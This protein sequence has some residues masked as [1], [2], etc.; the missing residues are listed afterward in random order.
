M[1]LSRLRNI[2][3]VAHIDAGKTTVTERI[4]YYTGV[5]HRMGEVHQGTTVMD[6]MEEERERG[7]TIT[8]AA[9]RCPWRDHAIQII[10]TPG[11]VDFTAEVSRSLRVLDGA[12]VVV[13]AVAGVQAQT[14]TV[15]RQA[16]ANEVPWIAF[17]NKMDRQGAD[18]QAAVESLRR[19]VEAPAV[20][21]QLPVGSGGEFE[22]VI[23]L[24]EL[25]LLCWRE[26]DKGAEV[27][28]RELTEEQ[29]VVALEARLRLC[30]AVAETS[31]DLLDAYLE[32]GDLENAALRAGL[33]RATL[34][35]RL[36]PV[37]A[38]SALRFAGIQPLLDGVL[39]WLPSPLER[40]PVRGH[41]PG[42]EDKEEIRDPDPAAPLTALVFKVAHDPHGDLCYLRVYSGILREGDQLHNARRARPER[43][44]AIYRMHADHRERLSEAG[45]GEIV[46]LPGLKHAQTGDTLFL[47]GHAIALEPIEFPD[48]VI[49]QTVEPRSLAERDKLFQALRALDREDPTLRV[50]VDEDTGQAMLAGMGE[51][52]LEVALHRLERDFR[53][54]ARAGRPVVA[55]RET[56]QSA[57]HG[58]GRAERPFADGR[59][60]AEAEVRVTP[61]PET[62]PTLRLAADLDGFAGAPRKVFESEAPL[63]LQSGGDLGYPLA[64][65]AVEIV[66]LDWSPA[67]EPPPV[68]LLL[69]AV[70]RA[71]DRAIEG[72][73][74]LLE[75][76]M[77]LRVEVPE[78][79]LAGVMADL[80][81]RRAE[82]EELEVVQEL[83]VVRAR[84]PLEAMFA[85]STELRSL[86]Q[87]RGSF[88]LEPWGYAPVPEARSRE[89]LEGIV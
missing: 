67:G 66:R 33:R 53:L 86:T 18:F 60:V 68:E 81:R 65:I 1:D 72:G 58:E 25:R 38:G 63:L 51:L 37:L 31:E 14:E 41:R 19:Q 42:A 69:G 54:Q 79:S 49:R 22:G 78:E 34:A 52:H 61:G 59:Q 20:P 46:V 8:A 21:V 40:P 32:R 29:R 16:A 36:V 5:E 82:V 85:Y 28:V 71:I 26:E 15:L 57:C 74:R 24:L 35:R 47:K 76:V 55:Y 62:R 87:G 17:I 3:I 10:D 13:C 30:E 70:S 75:P 80:Q 44:Q 39:A 43:A 56:V 7:I 11:H 50:T 83:R 88:S 2:G 77:T 9:T 12:V 48:P 4:L 64:R 27:E 23:D 6:W 84:A 73:T 89:I 45:P